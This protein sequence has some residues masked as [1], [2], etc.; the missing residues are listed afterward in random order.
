VNVI[1]KQDGYKQSI[2]Q[3]KMDESKEQIEAN[4]HY[5]VLYSIVLQ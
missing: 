2:G 1:G 3:E 5:T 4:I